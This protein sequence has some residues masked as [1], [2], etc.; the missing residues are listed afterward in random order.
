MKGKK[1]NPSLQMECYWEPL[2]SSQLD[3]YTREEKEYEEFSKKLESFVN[4]KP[5]LIDQGDHITLLEFTK[6]VNFF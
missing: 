2:S 5:D 3:Y 6:L 4:N 1:T